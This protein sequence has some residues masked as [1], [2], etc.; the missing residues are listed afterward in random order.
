M[1]ALG[2]KDLPAASATTAHDR[3]RPW[4]RQRTSRPPT[5]L[6]WAGRRQLTP[7]LA[8]LRGR[9]P[10]WLPGYL[11]DTGY[12]SPVTSGPG[13][14]TAP[15]GALGDKCRDHGGG[16]SAMPPTRRARPVAPALRPTA[17]SP[18]S[19]VRRRRPVE[20]SQASEPCDPTR[21]DAAHMQ[22]VPQLALPGAAGTHSVPARHRDPARGRLKPP[23]DE[24]LDCQIGS[25]PRSQVDPAHGRP[26]RPRLQ[27]LLDKVTGRAQCRLR[28][29]QSC[30]TMRRR[31]QEGARLP[32]CLI[33]PS[34]P[35]KVLTCSNRSPARG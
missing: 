14:V 18:A 34:P 25:R 20:T 28:L 1:W 12:S 13:W 24:N 7:S 8:R 16:G 11:P 30:A 6:F 26:S 22:S 35:K 3:W 9:R 29:T 31:R 10:G 21:I 27:M 15:R 33:P 5:I 17:D 23:L 19:G 2:D 32:E 4:Q